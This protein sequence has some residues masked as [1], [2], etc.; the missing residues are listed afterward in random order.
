MPV[1]AVRDVKDNGSVSCA[2]WAA[3]RCAAPCWTQGS[4]AVQFPE[5]G[6]RP[7][8]HSDDLVLIEVVTRASAS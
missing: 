5:I 3:A 2:P 6:R 1:E 7:M 8:A 4:V